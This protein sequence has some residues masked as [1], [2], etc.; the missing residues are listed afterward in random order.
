MLSVPIPAVRAYESASIVETQPQETAA[1][2]ASHVCPV[3]HNFN[4]AIGIVTLGLD[5][6]LNSK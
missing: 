1:D 4:G 5:S 3:L 2:P 6:E